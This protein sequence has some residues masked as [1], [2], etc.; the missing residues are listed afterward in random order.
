[1]YDMNQTPSENIRLYAV[2]GA[3]CAENT[4]E[5]ISETVAEMF[6]AIFE[7]NLI[8]NEDIVSVQFTMTSDLNTLNPCTA[9]R[10]AGFC[11]GA[12]LFCSQEAEIVGMLPKVIRVLITYYG[13]CRPEAVY[14]NGAQ[15]LRPDL[16][17]NK[18]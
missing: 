4:P 3:T 11:E 9:L 6:T 13:T 17:Q 1:M 8:K 10:R 14:L 15:K 7:K 12:P 2:R 5:S 18:N 16:A